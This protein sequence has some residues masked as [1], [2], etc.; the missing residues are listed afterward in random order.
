MDIYL[1]PEQLDLRSSVRAFLDAEY[2]PERILQMEQ[3]EEYP[4]DFYR[5][6]AKRG[7][8]GIPVPREHGGSD[9]SVL[10][11]CVFVEEVGKTSISLSTLYITGTIF[12]SHALHICGS[13]EQAAHY[14]PGIVSGE[15]RFALAMSEPG[16]GSDFAG[17]A[18]RAERVDGGW[19]IDGIKGPISGAE[20]AEVIIT[21]ARTA[22]YPGASRQKG[23]SLFLV[24]KG[25]SGPRFER[26]PYTAMRALM[27]NKVHYEGLVVPDSAMLGPLD[28]GWM[29]LARLMDPERL[30]NAA[31]TIGVAQAAIDD[32]V[33]YA[34]S[35]ESYGK[36]ISRYQAV[37]HPLA[38]AQAEVAAARLLVYAAAAKRDREGPCPKEASMAKMLANNVAF[39]ATNAALQCAGA[40]GYERDSHFMRRVLEVRGCELGGGTSQIQR[41]II[42]RFMGLG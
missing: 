35:R 27:V 25:P 20:R 6:C 28:E 16:A 15:K 40:R 19:R 1:S 22:S 11:L 5:E 24:E 10:D 9:G 38:E 33:A 2:P 42:G 23:I 7:W 34:T 13:Q 31:Q 12:G 18:T 39:R 3:D 30:A 21:A 36:P 4:D 8:T 41:N 29:N 14:L 37:S 17:M 26:T 32:G